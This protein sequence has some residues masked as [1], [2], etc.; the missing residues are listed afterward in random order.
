VDGFH[1]SRR[2]RALKR[3]GDD[4]SARSSSGSS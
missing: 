2:T 4:V 3:N 1:G